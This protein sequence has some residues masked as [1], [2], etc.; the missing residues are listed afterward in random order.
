MSSRGD[1]KRKNESIEEGE[2]RKR[3]SVRLIPTW[4]RDTREIWIYRE[5]QKSKHC[6]LHC[7]N[8]FM[9]SP[10]AFK[11]GL[12]RELAKSLDQTERDLYLNGRH[13]NNQLLQIYLS[14]ESGNASQN[15]NFS[16]ETI[17]RALQMS[18]FDLT[19]IKMDDVDKIF[20]QEVG[21]IV[22]S[23][24]HWIAYR[25]IK[26]KWWNLDSVLNEPVV[27]PEGQLVETLSLEGSILFELSGPPDKM[28]SLVQHA[29]VMPPIH[30]FDQSVW[31]TESELLRRC[32]DPPGKKRE[33]LFSGL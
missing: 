16:L 25:K 11:I 22:H 20:A 10:H 28:N 5:P 26:G 1:K 33:A 14:E 24:L 19:A 2:N 13:G 30:D 6:G 31:F 4:P 29:G 27:V 3:R 21:F 32:R 18:G 12:L 8:N 15:G 9:Q 17:R 7:L 23:D